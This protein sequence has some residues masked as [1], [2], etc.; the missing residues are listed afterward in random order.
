MLHA[1]SSTFP[2]ALVQTIVELVIANLTGRL[3][4]RSRRRAAERG[5]T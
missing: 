3:L 5:E 2:L 4:Y 1:L